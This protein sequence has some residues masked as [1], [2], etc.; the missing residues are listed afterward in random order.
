MTIKDVTPDLDTSGIL[1]KIIT[2]TPGEFIFATY[3]STKD[4]ILTSEVIQGV[5]SYCQDNGC[6]CLFLPESNEQVAVALQD[7]DAES[8]RRLE[9]LVH[10]AL[11][12]KSKILLT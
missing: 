9:G 1:K 7:Y 5:M 2:C 4:E 3:D 8:L 12:K 6:P 11:Q 10:Q